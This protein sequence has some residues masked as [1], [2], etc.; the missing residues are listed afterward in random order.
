MVVVFIVKELNDRFKSKL[1]VPIPIEVIMVCITQHN[2]SNKQLKN[3]TTNLWFYKGVT[4]L[5]MCKEAC[6]TIWDVKCQCVNR[7]FG[8]QLATQCVSCLLSST[9]CHRM[10]GFICIW[11]QDKIWDWRCWLY[12]KRVGC[13]FVNHTKATVKC[14]THNFYKIDLKYKRTIP[15]S[16]QY[17]YS[18]MWLIW[19]PWAKG[20]VKRSSFFCCCF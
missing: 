20:K 10:W 8:H 3:R 2:P 17:H 13:A 1:P 7:E 12:P 15:K 6:I 19:L 16:C 9:D 5:F 4:T 18:D 11:L 14:I